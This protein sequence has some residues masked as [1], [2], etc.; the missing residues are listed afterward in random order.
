MATYI[1]QDG[2]DGQIVPNITLFRPDQLNTDNWIQTI[3]DFG[4]KYAILVAK[5]QQPMIYRF[6]FSSHSKPVV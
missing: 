4:A 1:E 6:S 2:C 3:N 5:V